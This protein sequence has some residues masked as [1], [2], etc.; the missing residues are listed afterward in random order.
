MRSLTLAF[1]FALCPSL[2][3]AKP[4]IILIYSDDHG[5]ADLGVLGLEKDLKTP[6]L[7]ALARSGVIAKN[8][9]STAPQCVPSRGGLMVGRL[10]RKSVV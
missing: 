8:G 9:Y 6:N 4:N 5:H 3:A 10:D 7:D 1:L 2:H